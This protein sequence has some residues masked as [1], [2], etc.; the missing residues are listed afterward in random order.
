MKSFSALL[1]K[2]VLN[3]KRWDTSAELGLAIAVWMEKIHQ[4]RQRQSAPPA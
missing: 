4:R 3:R 1:Q 2:T